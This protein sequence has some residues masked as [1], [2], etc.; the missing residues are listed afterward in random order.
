LFA[1]EIMFFRN[2]FVVTF[3]FSL[4]EFLY[5]LTINYFIKKLYVFIKH[6]NINLKNIFNLKFINYM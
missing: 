3:F 2:E 5:V 6:V 4:I 1:I